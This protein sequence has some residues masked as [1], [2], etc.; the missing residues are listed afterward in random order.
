MKAF[1][2][3]VL[4]AVAGHMLVGQPTKTRKSGKPTVD[5]VSEKPNS[6]KQFDSLMETDY[7]INN[8]PFADA[9]NFLEAV[10]KRNAKEV[11]RFIYTYKGWNLSGYDSEKLKAAIKA[12]PFIQSLSND[13]AKWLTDSVNFEMK[14]TKNKKGTMVDSLVKVNDKYKKFWADNPAESGASITGGPES[15]FPATS[16][17]DGLGTFIAE[18]FKEELTIK[19]IKVFRDSVMNKDKK[20][21]YSTLLPKTYQTLELYQNVFDY[22][23]LLT[24]LKEAFK[25]DLDNL[26]TNIFDFL[27]QFA[28][29]DKLQKR[30][31]EVELKI[32]DL[33]NQK[34]S[35]SEVQRFQ[36]EA[37]LLRGI[38][39][40]VPPALYF[41]NFFVN[42]ISKGENPLSLFESP[43]NYK[44]HDSLSDKT[45]TIL[46]R[47]SFLLANLKDNSGKYLGQKDLSEF[48]SE[49]FTNAFLGLCLLKVEDAKI[50]K[51]LQDNAPKIKSFNIIISSS[52]HAADVI[53]KYN[54]T[55][56]SGK[57]DII[58]LLRNIS[59]DFE[60]IF[61][62]GE[63][64]NGEPH[65]QSK[66]VF[67]LINKLLLLAEYARD[68]KYGLVITQSITILDTLSIGAR[69]PHF[70]ATYKKYGLFIANVAQAKSGA[71]VKEVLEVAAL[72]V[73]SYQIKR[74]TLFDISLNTYAGV[75]VGGE[76]L[77]SDKGTNPNVHN[78]AGIIG[79]TA[80]V[81]LAFSWGVTTQ[82]SAP[83]NEFHNT[84]TKDTKAMYLTG[85]SW[86]TF[87]SIIDV[88]A[89]TA[90]RLSNDDTQ[91]LPDFTWSNIVAP[92]LYEIVGLKNTPLSIGA[93][94]QLGPQLRS[95]SGSTTA[96]I[97]ESNWSFRV[98]LAVD[99]P[100]FSFYSKTTK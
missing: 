5:G 35:E 12:N 69:Y 87:L 56:A 51:F 2:L 90:F 42:E 45:S 23:S 59:D 54:T 95:V 97:S 60:K 70:F 63:K 25:T 81:G 94:A 24:A 28:S 37:N 100:I 99:I 34:G 15:I 58:Q 9:N 46:N 61:E 85:T 44:Y 73:G 30:L 43:S 47:I 77:N 26:H 40:V 76:Q 3:F 52:I 32:K 50:E 86:T 79:F 53:N 83:A 98:F 21:H 82:G 16:V 88:G 62:E 20:L 55:A 33:A 31:L 17:A 1:Y 75:F 7:I 6:S 38:Q 65:P 72:P 18:R 80:P 48:T 91:N 27:D 71:E 29:K 93:G 14:K 10:D 78:S 57:G 11:I 89:I 22:K 13:L 96:N 67:N 84:F 36:A 19:Y 4:L 64:L 74:N 8:N 92:G 41:S 49:K 68:E 66:I 39:P